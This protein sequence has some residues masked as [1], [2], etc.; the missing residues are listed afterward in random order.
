MSDALRVFV[1]EYLSGS[2]PVDVDSAALLGSALLASERSEAADKAFR[3]AARFGWRNAATQGYFYATALEAGDLRVAADR[4]DA[5]LRT[6]PRVVDQQRLLEPIESDPAGRTIL[7][8]HLLQQP[9]W[10]RSYLTLPAD[11]SP[12]LVERRFLVISQVG[13]RNVALGCDV[14]APFAKSLL[15]HDRWSDAKEFW[16]RNCPDKRVSG[17]VGDPAFTAV[18]ASVGAELPFTWS[19][20]RSGDVMIR[21][22]GAGG[23][24]VRMANSTSASRLV[25][26][27]S[28][29]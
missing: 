24:G 7:A 4:A 17:L 20:L 11:S 15:K 27:S 9:P 21:Q 25:R 12:E 5:L 6:H 8:G 3:V 10:I 26:R 2:D 14:A 13:A 19:V 22:V 23:S 18:N 29:R 28:R 16:N 1:Y